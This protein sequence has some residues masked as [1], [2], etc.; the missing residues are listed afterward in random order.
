MKSLEAECVFIYFNQDGCENW[1][2]N[3][4]DSWFQS[5]LTAVA[6]IRKLQNL[7]DSGY[8]GLGV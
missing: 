1:L 6:L 2:C 4:S 7:T 5:M 8:F 3:V